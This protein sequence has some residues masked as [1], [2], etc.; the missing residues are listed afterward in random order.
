MAKQKGKF[1]LSVGDEGGILTYVHGK[2]VER[3]FFAPTPNY[4]DTKGFLDALQADPD[5]P[6]T[7]LIDVMD[8]SY[9]Q[10]SL[11]PVSA[12][13]VNNLIKRKMERD[14]AAEDLKGALQI[15]REKE[16]R[17]DW[18]YLFVT[19]SRS[20]QLEA[21]L[22]LVME[23]SNPFTGIYL[24][25][26]EAENFI[27]RLHTGIT[28]ETGKKKNPA[29]IRSQWQLLVA[30][31]KV[32]GFRQVVLK[33]GKLIFARLA[34]P[35]GDNQ[36]EVIAGNIEQEISVTTE[37]LK[38]LGYADDQG[39]DVYVIASE[40]IKASIDA[41]NINATSAYVMSPHEAALKIGLDQV[42]DV[43]DQ[44]A[45]V[46][47]AAV[48]ATSKKHLLRLQTPE[49][50]K[51]NKLYS[52]IMAAKAGGALLTL[53][54]LG[55]IGYYGY[56][57]PGAKTEIEDYQNQ[58]G[59][60]EE[61]LLQV[62]EQEKKL[63]DDL[64]RMTDLVAIHQLLTNMGLNPLETLRTLEAAFEGGNQILLTDIK[65][66]VEKTLISAT[67]GASGAATPRRRNAPASN[68]AAPA[69]QEIMTLLLSLDMYGT[70]VG[71]QVFNG[72][73]DA[74]TNELREKFPGFT[75]SL[76]SER[77]G[78]IDKT[79]AFAVGQEDVDPILQSPFF[80]LKYEI[81]GTGVVSEETSE[82]SSVPA[83]NRPRGDRI[84]E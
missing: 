47:L 61:K 20:P 21:W 18:K 24:L 66:S 11:P 68:T 75:V 10:Q 51:L 12:F 31:N 49:L 79:A 65:W 16:G 57:V 6:I 7:M 46:L 37:Y 64:E 76:T 29:E 71:S 69:N 22:N 27:H 73:I 38:R 67:E 83:P 44:F 58:I 1:I 17:R 15:G 48:F 81:K 55:A 32:G 53:A 41:S 28:G 43:N 74:F 56:L 3:R 4:S 78:N 25:P 40:P 52:G 13:S 77:P 62:K 45:D 63:P 60:A 70:E 30:H 84:V 34:Q 19:L 26:V 14:F 23:L 36:P 50:E 82:T 8:Q 9:V 33:N 54:A 59:T 5:A 80:G 35:I 72:R 39:M 42:T 2:T